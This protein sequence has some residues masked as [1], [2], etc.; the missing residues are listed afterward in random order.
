[1]NKAE[2]RKVRTSKILILV[3]IGLIALAAF[4]SMYNPQGNSKPVELFSEDAQ[5]QISLELR[6]DQHDVNDVIAIDGISVG[7]EI[8]E[9]YYIR[10]NHRKN[11]TLMF[12]TELLSSSGDIEDA[13]NVRVYDET[14]DKDLYEGSLS[15]LDGRSF[16]EEQITNAADANDTR[17]RLYF[18][19]ANE[20]DDRYKNASAQL[21]VRWFIPEEQTDALKMSKSG[22][23]KV[24]LY[25]F[26]AMLVITGI[27]FFF[28][29]KRLNPAV[30]SKA[31]P[32]F[33]EE[34]KAAIDALGKKEIE[35]S[36]G[37]GKPRR[38]KK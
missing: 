27:M 15:G 25:A 36:D 20:N 8:E 33:D 32:L 3:I 22:D 9:V 11:V 5:K 37:S 26:I 24:I 1:M 35:G 23:V 28:L 16:S 19:L 13:L 14:H 34:E 29:H 18:S 17:Y 4:F 12:E 31:N 38:G 2:R 30:Y 6:N 21:E 10:V 7:E